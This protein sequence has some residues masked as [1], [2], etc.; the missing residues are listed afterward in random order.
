MSVPLK[1]LDAVQ[2]SAALFRAVPAAVP[3]LELAAFA[4]EGF[5]RKETRAGVSYTD[6]YVT[7]PMRNAL[8]LVRLC[9]PS[10]SGME[11]LALANASLLHDTVEDAP[12]RV[13]EFF[14]GPCDGLDE[15]GVRDQALSLIGEFF[16]SRV[17]NT[18]LRVT[19]PP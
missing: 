6:P 7:H 11:M 16:G 10:L 18:V 3:A 14:S 4:H 17:Q 1:R 15:R 5:F 9:S 19:N 8:R 2:L 13:C 12:G